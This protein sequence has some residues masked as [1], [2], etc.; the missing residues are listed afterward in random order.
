[1][2]ED[3]NNAYSQDVRKAAIALQCDAGVAAG[4][5]KTVIDIVSRNIF[6]HSFSEKLPCAQSALN[7][8]DEGQVII[9]SKFFFLPSLT[10]WKIL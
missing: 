9:E 10:Q 1:M 8:V 4:K 7:M 5:V 6:H 2:K 3:R